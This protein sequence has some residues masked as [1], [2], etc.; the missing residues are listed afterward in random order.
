[1]RMFLSTVAAALLLGGP[2]LA[3]GGHPGRHVAPHAV[4]HTA[5]HTAGQ[6]VHHPAAKAVPLIC[7]VTGDKIASKAKAVGHTTYKG[8]T[9]YFCCPE[10]KP[11]FDKNPQHYLNNAA[12]G[13][14]EKM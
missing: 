14:F 3:S 5:R 9:Y 6:A 12:H 10:C 13:K 1:M 2:A 4:R 7:P 8:K 11:K